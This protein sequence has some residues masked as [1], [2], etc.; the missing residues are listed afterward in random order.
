[1]YQLHSESKTY[2]KTIRLIAITNS[3]AM[4]LAK[5]NGIEIIDKN[6]FLE[7]LTLKEI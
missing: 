3:N 4:N 6:N 7:F 5:V 1:M 2:Y